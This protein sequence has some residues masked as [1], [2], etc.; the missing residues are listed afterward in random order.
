MLRMISIW[1]KNRAV[2]LMMLVSLTLFAIIQ[3]STPS[4]VGIDGH[5]HIKMAYLMRTEGLKP[6]F[7]YLEFSILNAQNC[8]LNI[9][10]LH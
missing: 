10:F 5:Y 4:I 8:I 2:L 9:F 6:Y 1:K 7:P 3:F